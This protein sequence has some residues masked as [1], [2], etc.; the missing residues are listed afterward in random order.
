VDGH[1]EHF[2][3][4]ARE[5]PVMIVTNLFRERPE[6]FGLETVAAL[7]DRVDNMVSLKEDLQGEFAREACRMTH[8]RWAVFSGGG[9]DNHWNLHPHGC[10]GFMD[11][12]MNF[13]PQVSHT[14]WSALKANDAVSARQVIDEVEA[15]LAGFMATFPGGRDAAIHGL[16][17]IYGIAG[18]WRRP[19]YHSLTDEE[20]DRLKAFCAEMGLK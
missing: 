17:E 5:L 3:A 1:V 9:L 2:R 20:L 19:P 15:P 7:R 6:A 4:V 16:L 11:R 18:R 12:H 13:R 14:Y 8:E 10:V